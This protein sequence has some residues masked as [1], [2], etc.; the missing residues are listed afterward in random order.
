MKLSNQNINDSI[1]EIQNFFEALRVPRK[2][3]IKISLLLEEAL[4][5]YQEKFGEDHEFKLIIKK[6]FGTPKVLIRI[7]GMPYNPI[8]DNDEQI[9]SSTMIKTLLSYEQTGVTYRYE[10]GN[11]E[12]SAFSTA[13]QARKK[14]PGGFIT[15]AI[16]LPIILGI[17]CRYL[18]STVQNIL[19]EGFVTPLF[20]TLIGTL[21]TLNLPLIFVS[22]ASGI[23]AV[24]DVAM[25]HE[26]GGKILRRFLSLMF[27]VAFVS[28]FVSAIFFP[29]IKFNLEG[30]VA[31][32]SLIDIKEIYNLILSILPQGIFKPFIDK[33]ILQ[34]ISLAFI[35]GISISILGDRVRNIK[36]FILEA[37]HICFKIIDIVFKLLP[38]IIFLCLFKTFLIYSVDEILNLWRIIAAK[39]ILFGMTAFLML[40]Y[41]SMKYGIKISDF[42]KKIQ[43]PLMIAFKY[44]GGLLTLEKNLE[45]CKKEL[46]VE[47]NLC[48]LYIP[49]SHTLCQ[50]PL[51]I[52]IVINL[53]FAAEFSGEQISVSQIFIVIFLAVQFAM[54]A[55][56]GNG[57]MIAIM[58][59]LLTQMKFSLDSLGSIA[60][61]DLFTI[62]FSCAVALIIRDCDLYDLSQRLKLG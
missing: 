9:F 61:S 41:I 3:K 12:L 5:R 51:V 59:L 2:D 18:P 26:V 62:N 44:A 8:E 50:V 16:I 60:L 46:K 47:K 42:L 25:L 34:I 6:W 35:I 21:I 53:F 37:R 19:A 57:G 45:V 38:I 20:N 22:I 11:N 40:L 58:S 31:L 1:E 27:L 23:F 29:V 28:V 43:P 17:L 33:N 24:E 39:Y 7:K 48:E 10:G 14:I 30:G 4:L 49:L 13:K 54:S 36:T 56:G 52:G 32:S 55:A 15:V